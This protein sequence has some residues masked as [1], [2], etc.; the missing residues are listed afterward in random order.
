MCPSA[1]TC[2]PV[3]S[4]FSELALC[5]LVQRFDLPTTNFIV[6]GLTQTGLEPTIYHTRGEHPK[7]YIT[8][9]L[10][11]DV[12]DAN[13]VYNPWQPFGSAIVYYYI[14]KIILLSFTKQSIKVFKH[15]I[16]VLKETT[17]DVMI[18]EFFNDYLN[19][20]AQLYFTFI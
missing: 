4:C 8:N 15:L 6:F 5:N 12:S 17:F 9:T 13:P 1:A 2:L 3:D 14:P 18:V 7:H 20:G 19:L 16:V 11:H 10:S